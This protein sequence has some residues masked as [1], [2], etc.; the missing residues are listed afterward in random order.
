M[1]PVSVSLQWVT[2]FKSWKSPST[3]LPFDPDEAMPTVSKLA[4]FDAIAAFVGVFLGLLF[5]YIRYIAHAHA[6]AQ[7]RAA[8]ELADEDEPEVLSEADGSV[9]ERETALSDPDDA[10]VSTF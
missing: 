1:P 8:V 7:R 3:T 9:V 10:E 2:T 4:M 6:E 5:R